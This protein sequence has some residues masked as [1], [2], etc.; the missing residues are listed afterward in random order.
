M[1]YTHNSFSIILITFYALLMIISL[2]IKIIKDFEKIVFVSRF[3]FNLIK[4]V[5][6]FFVTFL[7]VEIKISVDFF[8]NK[9]FISFLIIFF[10]HCFEN[11]R[12]IFFIRFFN[13]FACLI[14]NNLFE[15]MIKLIR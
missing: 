11:K 9:E 8:L 6:Y 2:V 14:L 7:Y 10:E 15:E 3:D 4:K 1:C 13:V 12:M 5:V